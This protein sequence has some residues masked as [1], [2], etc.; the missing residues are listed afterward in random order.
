MD[1]VQCGSSCSF[2]RRTAILT[3]RLFDC[4][5]PEGPH[6]RAV[7]VSSR[8]YRK[9]RHV[10]VSSMSCFDFVPN[11]AARAHGRTGEAAAATCISCTECDRPQRWRASIADSENLEPDRSIFLRPAIFCDPSSSMTYDGRRFTAAAATVVERC[12]IYVKTA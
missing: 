5:D 3:Q 6:D 11:R 1:D 10:G 12:R 4:R 8:S 2:R 7:V 9:R